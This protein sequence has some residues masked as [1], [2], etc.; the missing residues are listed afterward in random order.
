MRV[1][2]RLGH[3]TPVRAEMPA[4]AE[5]N[6]IAGIQ[7]CTVQTLSWATASA[8]IVTNRHG[9]SPMLACG[10]PCFYK[11]NACWFTPGS[12]SL[13][14]TH[15]RVHRRA[16]VTAGAAGVGAGRRGRRGRPA[17]PREALPGTCTRPRRRRRPRAL[18]AS[19]ARGRCRFTRAL[20]R[21]LDRGQAQASCA[22]G[23]RTRLAVKRRKPI[24]GR[25]V[26]PARAAACGC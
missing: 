4:K 22:E 21:I 13:A 3:L 14:R 15:V 17:A 23:R 10:R 7:L 12:L 11:G 9:P 26:V 20:G 6:I 5:T 2:E 18:K 1:A 25:A 19:R 8:I 16:G 24:W